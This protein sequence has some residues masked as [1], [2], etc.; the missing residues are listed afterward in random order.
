MASVKEMPELKRGMAV[1]YNIL[2]DGKTHSRSSIASTLKKAGIKSGH[3]S[4]IIRLGRIGRKLKLFDV[5]ISYENGAADEGR[6][7]L[8]KGSKASESI[9]EK[10]ARFANLAGTHKA[11]KSTKKTA[12]HRTSKPKSKKSTKKTAKAKKPVHAGA[13]SSEESSENEVLES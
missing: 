1:V 11:K 13:A 12:K 9:K 6:V 4:R 2:K 8:V 7:Q 3:Y 5:T 10:A